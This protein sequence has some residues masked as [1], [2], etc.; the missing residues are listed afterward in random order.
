MSH[1]QPATG[2]NAVQWVSELRPP[3]E[4]DQ[5]CKDT[6]VRRDAQ[7]GWGGRIAAG[8]RPEGK[9]G[10]PCA[11]FTEAG[12]RRGTP[13]GFSTREAYLGHIAHKR[14]TYEKTKRHAVSLFPLCSFP[15]VICPLGPYQIHTS[16]MNHKRSSD[17]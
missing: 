1:A 2:T 9:R 4:T 16:S 12:R 13:T 10:E 3:S 6:H 17:F 8:A 7:T 5:K 11:P 15:L 14:R